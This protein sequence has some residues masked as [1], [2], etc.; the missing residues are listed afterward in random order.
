MEAGPDV[1]AAAPA[2][3]WGFEIIR[4]LAASLVGVVLSGML[5]QRW[6]LREK[7]I[8]ERIAELVKEVDAA[9]DLASSYWERSPT[10]ETKTH[11]IRR[12]RAQEAELKARQIRIARIR[13]S[14]ADYLDTKKM[15]DLFASEGELFRA[16][17]GE[18]FGS[19]S[20]QCADNAF[21]LIRGKSAEYL[22][23]VRQARRARIE[24]SF[25]SSIRH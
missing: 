19:P 21:A 18:D 4:L 16:F 8:E 10:L 3:N 11:D 9:A 13:A 1:A 6:Q 7:Y 22:N 15:R 12:D 14:V 20:R 5:L 2:I 24:Q 17:T 23:L 25:F